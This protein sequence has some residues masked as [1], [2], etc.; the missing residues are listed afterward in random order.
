MVKRT[1][2]TLLVVLLLVALAEPT[3]AAAATTDMSFG[4][5]T[6]SVS[7]SWTAQVFHIVVDVSSSRFLLPTPLE[8]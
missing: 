2:G 8:R 3:R 4:R 6:I 1:R 5:L 7:D